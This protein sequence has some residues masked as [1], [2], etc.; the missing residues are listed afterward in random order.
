MRQCIWVRF[1]GVC[2]LR[3]CV[4]D[5]H[6]P[7]YNRECV[8]S[9]ATSAASW[10]MSQH[11]SERRPNDLPLS[12]AAII[13]RYHGGVEIGLQNGRSLRAAQRRPLEWRV[14]RPALRTLD[15]GDTSARLFAARG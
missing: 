14:G 1:Q 10:C 6:T 7:Q 15:F 11:R 13:Q 12:C 8:Y 2:G 3:R 9:N 5:R 4:L